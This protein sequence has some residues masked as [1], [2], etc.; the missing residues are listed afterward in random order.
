MTQTTNS[1]VIVIP[2]DCTDLDGYACAVGYAE[3]L[4][5]RGIDSLAGYDG[6]VDAETSYVVSCITPPIF[7]SN[8]NIVNASKYVYVD[9]SNL[10]L[11]PEALSPNKVVEVI[12]HHF[13]HDVK[14]DFPNAIEDIQRIGAAA[15]LI[16]ERFKEDT[17]TPEHGT[18]VLLYCAIHSN[19]QGLNGSITTQ[20]DHDAVDWLSS[21][22]NIPKDIVKL[23]FNARKADIVSNLSA[24]VARESKKYYDQLSREYVIA[25]LELPDAS[26]VFNEERDELIKSTLSLSERAILNMVDVSKNES[27]ILI[28]NDTYRSEVEELIGMTF[29]N[30]CAIAS[31]IILRKQ[32][33]A[34]I[35]GNKW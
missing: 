15:T 25:Q 16:V 2:P 3:L 18:S 22:T 24:S 35:A 32:I 27:T 5:A 28:P 20:R 34:A 14:N 26:L 6:P 33:V 19:T 4:R 23:Q 29:T 12:D 13:P 1:K 7:E 11:F 17:R 21:I 30:S 31:P 9:G 8:K 10:Q